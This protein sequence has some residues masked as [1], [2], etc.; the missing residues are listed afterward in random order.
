MD[1]NNLIL[2][3]PEHTLFLHTFPPIALALFSLANALNP[4]PYFWN[5]FA[6]GFG[7]TMLS[8]CIAGCQ[9]ANRTRICTTLSRTLTAA[10]NRLEKLMGIKIA[11]LAG[12][13]LLFAPVFEMFFLAVS[14]IDWRSIVQHRFV[15]K[16]WILLSFTTVNV[17]S[18][19][20]VAFF[21]LL[22]IDAVNE[23]AQ[24][25]RR[26]SPRQLDSFNLNALS[27]GLAIFSPIFIAA[28]VGRF[29][30]LDILY[31][32]VLPGI[33]G[34]VMLCHIFARF[35]AKLALAQQALQA[36]AEPV[37]TATQTPSFPSR[38]D[39]MDPAEYGYIRRLGLIPSTLR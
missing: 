8:V 26:S 14:A 17:L 4:Q 10:E 9:E 13:M 28:M 37:P 34:H 27:S 3:T 22:T 31:A 25:I 29:G 12:M 11:A 21:G 18:I 32:M 39:N 35:F 19:V 38:P 5:M 23:L 1:I 7:S 24:R 6:L 15:P 33:V 20:S 36:K 16:H 2:T 30:I